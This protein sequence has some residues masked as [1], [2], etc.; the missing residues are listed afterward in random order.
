MT[1]TTAGDYWT[2]ATCHKQI[3]SGEA[4]SCGGYVVTSPVYAPFVGKPITDFSRIEKLL[5]EVIALLK[6]LKK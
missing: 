6:E 5:E 3:T 2:C 1:I 4:H